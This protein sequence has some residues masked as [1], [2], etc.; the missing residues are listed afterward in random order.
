M[1]REDITKHIDQLRIDLALLLKDENAVNFCMDLYESSQL[2]DDAYDDVLAQN[3]VYKLLELTMVKIPNNPFYR[4]CFNK[5]QPLLESYVLQ[6]QSSNKIEARQLVVSDEKEQ[7]LFNKAY[8]LRAYIFQI[9]HYCAKLLHG[10]KYAENQA[11]YFQLLYG[12]TLENYKKEFICQPP[13]L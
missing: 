2:F 8:S 9:F 5:L 3:E 12:E 4:V 7:E 10:D 13:Q 11:I 1:P 6:W